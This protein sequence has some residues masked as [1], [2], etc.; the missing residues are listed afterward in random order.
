MTKQI[1]REAQVEESRSFVL[2][3]ATQLSIAASHDSAEMRSVE[4]QAGSR[5]RYRLSYSIRRWLF[6]KRWLSRGVHRMERRWTGRLFSFLCIGGG[7]ALINVFCFSIVYYRMEHLFNGF[8]AYMLAFLV[9][10]EISIIANFIPNDRITFRYL[11]GQHRSW[12]MRCLRFHMT[13]MSGTGVTLGFSFTLLHLFHVPAFLAQAAALVA[14]T[15]FN[16]LFHHLFTY[17]DARKA[18]PLAGNTRLEEHCA[19]VEIDNGSTCKLHHA[20]EPEKQ[21]L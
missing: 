16:F 20:P 8:V 3:T 14:A 11:A 12:R 13:S 21:A 6:I 7:S 2:Q 18:I 19:A 15:A 10:T 17:R 9:A 5:W 1:A 4:A